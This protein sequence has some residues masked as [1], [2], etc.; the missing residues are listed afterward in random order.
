[1]YWR[2]IHGDFKEYA[3]LVGVCERNVGRLKLCRDTIRQEFKRD[4]PGYGEEDFDRMIAETKPDTVIVTTR[5]C[6]HARYICRAMELGCDAISEKPM[7]TDPEKCQQILDTKKRT[8]RKCTVTF[9][10]R[11]S[12]P[13]TQIKDLLMA[14]TIGEVLSVDFHWMLNVF[15]GADYFRRWHRNKANSGGLMVHKATHHF[16]LVNW[17][18]SSEPEKVYA[19]G[20]QSFYIPETAER[21]GLSDRSERCL[22]CPVSSRCPFFMDLKANEGLRKLYLDQESHDGYFRDRCVFSGQIDIEDNMHLTV[23][24]RGGP[25]MS[26]SLHA[27]LPWEGHVIYIN[28][29]KGRIEHKSEETTHIIGDGSTPGEL[30]PDG[31]YTRVYPQFG[32]PYLLDLWTGKG[33]H[34]GGDP[35]MLRDIFDPDAPADKYLRAADERAGAWSILTGAAANLSMSRGEPVRV[36]EIIS[37]LTAPDY[38]SMPSGREP[39]DAE[40]YMRFL[41]RKNR[42]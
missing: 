14:G 9:N 22:D 8:G 24:Y 28:G 18:L 26:Y 39:I 36:S 6:D 32:E 5:D 20:K 29:S 30:R 38:P 12:P 3:E 34:G 23:E 35:V 31:T 17:M 4:V 27:F 1:M 7:T 15:H 25:L 11:Y 2:A 41:A 13:R 21:M 40:A 19:Q 33:G 42:G 10:Y 37:G 16:D